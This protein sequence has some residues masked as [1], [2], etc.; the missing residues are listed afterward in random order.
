MDWMQDNFLQSSKGLLYW[1]TVDARQSHV[2]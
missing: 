2:C 1:K